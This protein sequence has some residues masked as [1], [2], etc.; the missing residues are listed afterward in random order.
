MTTIHCYFS[1]RYDSYSE[2]DPAWHQVAGS[3]KRQPKYTRDQHFFAQLDF[4][5][6]QA[7]YQRV[8][9]SLIYYIQRYT[10][11][12][13]GMQ[14]GLSSAPTVQFHPAMAGPNKGNKLS[15]ITYDMNRQ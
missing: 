10:K 9:L 7:V 11:L 3:W 14:L 13:F 6:G 2:F 15:V 8:R 1:R 4:A 12:T 5:D